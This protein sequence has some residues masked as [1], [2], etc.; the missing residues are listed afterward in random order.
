MK[1]IK[2][3]V[4]PFRKSDVRVYQPSHILRT[5]DAASLHCPNCG[6]A[7]GADAGR[8]PYCEA[9]LTTVSC[10]VCFA[11]LFDDAAFCPHC[12]TRRS[13]AE[14]A[15]AAAIC[16]N[17]RNALTD[18]TVGT[19]SLLEC[20]RCDGVWLTA[21]DFEQICASHDAQAAVLHRWGD[22]PKPA[23]SAAQR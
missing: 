9:R 16:P 19:T 1:S 5:M 11:R 10:P 12:G 15:G 14:G 18:V 17:C 8:C 20:A 7:V 22:P 23:A 13:R 4:L 21:R 6:A 3:M 2:P